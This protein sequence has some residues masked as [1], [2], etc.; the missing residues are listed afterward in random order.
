MYSLTERA[1]GA[2]QKNWQGFRSPVETAS[3]RKY[4][5]L[6]AAQP[7]ITML[8]GIC[9]RNRFIQEEMYICFHCKSV[10]CRKCLSEEVDFYF[11]P[12]CQ[13][14]VSQYDAENFRNRCSR[15]YECPNCLNVVNM[16]L[17]NHK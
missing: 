10:V 16:M 5:Q 6:Y 14:T 8:C 15:C 4:E 17:N 2:G 12:Q 1:A 11:C 7:S 3:A 9:E 13:Q